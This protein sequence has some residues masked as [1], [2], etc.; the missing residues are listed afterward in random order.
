MLCSIFSFG[1]DHHTL[2]LSSHLLPIS[3][4]WEQE[5][6]TLREECDYHPVKTVRGIWQW[7]QP[8]SV[9]HSIIFIF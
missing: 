3:L 8:V 7:L 9:I 4:A 1:L 6:N 5:N 2:F